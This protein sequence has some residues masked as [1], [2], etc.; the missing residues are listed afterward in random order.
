MGA[1][2]ALWTLRIHIYPAWSLR[3]LALEPECLDFKL[4][5]PHNQLCR[6]TQPISHLK[7]S[8]SSSIIKNNT[9]FIELWEDAWKTLGTM[10]GPYKYLI[11]VSHH[12]H[13]SSRCISLSCVSSLSSWPYQPPQK[14]VSPPDFPTTSPSPSSLTSWPFL[15]SMSLSSGVPHSHCV[16]PATD[17]HHHFQ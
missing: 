13:L 12:Q 1:P 9:Y 4:F 15:Q 14:P 17:T 6:S 7:V 10:P 5:P 3:T 8:F 11:N 2:Q 16:H